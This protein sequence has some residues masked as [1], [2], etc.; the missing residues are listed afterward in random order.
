[1][2]KPSSENDSVLAMRVKERLAELGL[3]IA[4]A[5][6]MAFG[7]D[8]TLRNILKGSS[9]NPRT[10]TMLKLA[11]TLQ[12]STEHLLGEPARD[13]LSSPTKPLPKRE[14]IN[15]LVPVFASVE[16]GDG[17]MVIDN[18]P[19]EWR[20]MPEVEAAAQ[21]DEL[22]GVVVEGLSMSRA[23]RP[24]ETVWLHPR[25][26]ERRDEA[27]VFRRVDNITGEVTATLK[28]LVDFNSERWLVEQLNPEKRF[29]LKRSEWPECYRV[30]GKKNRS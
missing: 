16:G 19:I 22:Y 25:F 29:E 15:K 4:E 6:N 21:D 2:K 27:C 11:E 18:G 28:W 26:R 8:G 9:K 7:N 13:R 20:G 23:Y 14:K 24:G 30:L 3:S 1:M 10:D 17:A 12:T 5:S